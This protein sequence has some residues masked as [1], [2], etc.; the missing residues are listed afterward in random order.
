MTVFGLDNI[1]VDKDSSGLRYV[2]R[3]DKQAEPLLFIHFRYVWK[4]DELYQQTGGRDKLEALERAIVVNGYPNDEEIIKLEKNEPGVTRGR[5]FEVDATAF[6]VRS[7]EEWELEEERMQTLREQA[8]SA[9]DAGDD[10]LGKLIEEN[11]LLLAERRGHL[12]PAAQPSFPG[13]RDVFSGS[14]SWDEEQD[15]EEGQRQASREDAFP[16]ER[17]VRFGDE[18]RRP[19]PKPE[20]KTTTHN[21]SKRKIEL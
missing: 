7:D 4:F 6:E 14:N 9:R 10:R 17:S 12:Q 3:P 20:P 21:P 19:Q 1:W 2:V 15:Y 11:M 16:G 18:P 13:R 8:S 5:P